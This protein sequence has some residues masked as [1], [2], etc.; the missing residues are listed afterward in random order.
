[1]L[2]YICAPNTRRT[3]CRLASVFVLVCVSDTKCDILLLAFADAPDSRE[4]E[5]EGRGIKA[6]GGGG[7]KRD[8]W[9]G[10][11][12]FTKAMERES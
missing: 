12:T 7:E 1:M 6:G 10:G 11:G 8:R 4:R 9:A 3:S 2:R 5:R